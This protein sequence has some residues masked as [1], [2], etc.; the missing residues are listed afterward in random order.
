[1][2]T[3]RS[4]SPLTL[5][6]GSSRR[7]IGDADLARRLVAG[8]A[9]AIGETWHRFAPMVLV[10]A[11]RA[12]GSKSE[13]QDVAQE[14]F[15]RVFSKAKTLREP[16]KFRSFIYSFAIRTLKAEL[17]RRKLRSWLSFDDPETLV[18][19]GGPSLDVEARDL[20]R[21]FHALLDR[22]SSRDRI[23]FVLRRME[24]MTVEE[25]SASMALS[26]STVK[27]SMAHA[28]GR[29]SRWIQSD[30]GLAAYFDTERLGR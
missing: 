20:L 12:L 6:A 27:R 7:E 2:A 13:A 30:P 16:D 21:R 4:H 11:E 17:H 24:S 8:D 9:W 23:V 26:R 19:I 22:L 1:M 10:M 5:V 29:L 18:D 28:S 3:H 14:T 15:H 25:I